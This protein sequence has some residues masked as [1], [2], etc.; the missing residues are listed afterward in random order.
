LNGWE[1][2][3]SHLCDKLPGRIVLFLYLGKGQQP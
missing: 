1:K 3:L 2:R